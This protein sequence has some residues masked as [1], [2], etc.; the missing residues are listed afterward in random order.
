ER[1][2]ESVRAQVSGFVVRELA[3]RHSNY[4]ATA[5]LG[6]WLAAQQVTG[7]SD[8]D[9][10]ALTR[11]LR[12]DGAMKGVLSTDPTQS[13]ADLVA[14]ARRAPGLVGVNLVGRV[15]RAKPMQW[16]DHLGAWRPIQGA[17]GE[18][19]ASRCRVVALD[20]G[21]KLNILRH[22]V[23][24]GCD[25][26]VLPWDAPV[27]QVREHK[28]DGL[29]VSNGPGDPAAVGATVET[30]RQVAGEVP[31]FGICLGHQ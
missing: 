19:G 9:T 26:T 13:D 29:F 3:A 11:K 1:D 27:E 14:L 5:A 16:D 7:I 12:I 6:D 28:P 21:A 20:C 22:L 8:L 18:T 24:V 17:G 2:L 25:V 23:D 10:R 30:L 4:R 15:S 31:T